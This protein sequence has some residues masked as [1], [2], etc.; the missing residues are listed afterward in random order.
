M[1][2]EYPQVSNWATF[3]LYPFSFPAQQKDTF[4]AALQKAADRWQPFEFS[5]QDYK[6]H[7]GSGSF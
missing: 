6:E 4:C 7:F 1:A 5:P 3:F 2:E